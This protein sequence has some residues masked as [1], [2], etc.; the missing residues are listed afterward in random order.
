MV[1][2]GVFLGALFISQIAWAG[3]DLRNASCWYNAEGE[4]FYVQTYVD[5]DGIY[6]KRNCPEREGAV[7]GQ[8]AMRTFTREEWEQKLINKGRGP[9]FVE[10]S[11]INDREPSMADNSSWWA[12]TYTERQA[13]DTTDL[14]NDRIEAGNNF[15]DAVTRQIENP[16]GLRQYRPFGGDINVRIRD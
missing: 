13:R 5:E 9:D 12:D 6:Q 3:G 2:K 16:G 8:A 15:I 10:Y 7:V 11:I 14:Y 4:L 1:N